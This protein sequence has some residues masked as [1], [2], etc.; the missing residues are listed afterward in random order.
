MEVVFASNPEYEGIFAEIYS[1]K[2]NAYWAR[3]L[4]DKARQRF[5]LI[6][7]PDLA[8]NTAGDIVLD[9]EEIQRLLEKAKTGLIDRGY[10]VE[11]VEQ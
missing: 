10:G 3:I 6:I 4:C 7:F 5:S 2:T 1:D 9:L 8:P 11:C